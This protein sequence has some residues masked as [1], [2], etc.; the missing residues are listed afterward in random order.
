MSGTVT[1]THSSGKPIAW[2]AEKKIALSAGYN[3]ALFPRR[4]LMPLARHCV[5]LTL[6][7]VALAATMACSQ[8][9]PAPPAAVPPVDTAAV[10][11]AVK[12]AIKTQV[13]AY[14][15]KD[16]ARAASILADDVV[17]HFHGAPNV[18]GRAAATE[19]MKEQMA[20]P[21]LTLA[22]ADE[23][24]DVAAAGDMAV[25]HA[26]YAFTFTNLATKKASSETGNWVAIFKRQ[27]DGTM[28]LSRDMVLDMPAK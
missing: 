15:A 13:D 19:G 27:E 16:A 17:G 1:G 2:S 3:G 26:T 10:A 25:Y 23:S 4:L 28:K 22:V 18:V 24:V 8:P 7:A 12:A 20:D 9:A 5:R 6:S 11:A 14:A 21:T